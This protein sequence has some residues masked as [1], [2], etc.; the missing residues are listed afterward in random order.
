MANGTS[1]EQNWRDTQKR[2]IDL[3]SDE[4]L[5]QEITILDDS[6]IFEESPFRVRVV[7]NSFSSWLRINP[8]KINLIRVL[9]DSL[10]RP[11]PKSWDEIINAGGKPGV[12]SKNK[13]QDVIK[14]NEGDGKT[15]NKGGHPGVDPDGEISK[16]VK[17]LRSDGVK[18]NNM[19]WEIR[20]TKIVQKLRWNNIDLKYR[21]NINEK[22]HPR[23]KGKEYTAKVGIS[24]DTAK[25]LISKSSN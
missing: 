4:I 13:S 9:L 2:V 14:S 11:F 20:F 16:K 1:K 8:D 17:E 23:I 7:F 24:L 3:I 25:K 15:K 22:I 12:E 10:D 19:P 18:N 6:T 5:N 21:Q